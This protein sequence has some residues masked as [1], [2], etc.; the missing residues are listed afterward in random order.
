MKNHSN[1]RWAPLHKCIKCAN[2]LTI[3]VK[4][5]I[6]KPNAKLFCDE[7]RQ[8]AQ[9]KGSFLGKAFRRLFETLPLYCWRASIEFLP[10]EKASRQGCLKGK[11]IRKFIS[12]ITMIDYQ[13]EKWRKSMRFWCPLNCSSSLQLKQV[14][15]RAV[16]D[17]KEEVT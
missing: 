4:S 1:T 3:N 15:P 6:L 7:T 10:A 2:L 17:L 12:N 16:M 14:R 11:M 13:I 8:M 5:C 9:Y